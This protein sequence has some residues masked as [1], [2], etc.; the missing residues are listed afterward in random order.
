LT[1]E[2][3]RRVLA[4]VSERLLTPV[5]LRTLAPGSE[6]YRPHYGGDQLARDGAYHQG[7]VWPWLL[8]PYLSAFVRLHGPSPQ[9][10]AEAGRLL[11]GLWRHLDDAGLGS[12]SEI[13]DADPPHAPRG[14]IS[15]AWSVAEVL[16]AYVED[17][18]GQAPD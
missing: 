17:V 1:G 8:G 12:I 2:R 16:R 14:C 15:Q 7:T 13:F 4:V 5:G 9:A 3:A 18:L 10:R 6:D 11:E